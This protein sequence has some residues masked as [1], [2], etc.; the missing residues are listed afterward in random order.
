MSLK[1]A[2]Q[3][4]TGESLT[5]AG[6]MVKVMPR[7]FTDVFILLLV[8]NEIRNNDPKYS[9]GTTGGS[10]CPILILST[11]KFQLEACQE[12]TACE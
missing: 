8:R 4:I 10:L 11:G 2:L 6:A 5:N 9:M 1:Y 7:H 3:F 12:A